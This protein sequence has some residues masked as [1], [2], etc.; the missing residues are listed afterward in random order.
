M[1][2]GATPTFRLTPPSI[3]VLR[4]PIDGTRL[5]LSPFRRINP[6]SNP[7]RHP[8]GA[9]AMPVS[10]HT[11]SW[12]SLLEGV[13]SP[14][15]LLAAGWRLGLQAVASTAAHLATADE[16]PLC[17]L[18]AAVR[19]GMLLDQLP[20]RTLLTPEHHLADPDTLRHRFRDLPEAVRNTDRI[21]DQ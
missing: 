9:P 15:E 5:A 6:S 11:H 17:R 10:L 4:T 1:V 7:A 19:Q 8:V 3:P 16:Y 13:P 21:A 2:S 14:K 20:A 12:Y 18:L